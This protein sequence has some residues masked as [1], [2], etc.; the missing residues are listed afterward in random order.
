MTSAD[1]EM[2]TTWQS[3][4]HVREWWASEEPGTVEELVDPRVERWIV[5]NAGHPFAYIQDYTVHGWDNHHFF[6]LPTG[7]RGIDQFIAEEGMIGQGHGPAFISVHLKKLFLAGAPVVA[8]D[9]DPENVRAIA[10][11]KK[12]GFEVF[13]P[14]RQTPW[15][16]ILP[17]RINR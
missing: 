1:F 7:S 2:M 8:T 15:G 11:Y 4:P 12:S 17:M 6:D 16:R 9:P 5:S 10:A 14:A 3:H 13:G